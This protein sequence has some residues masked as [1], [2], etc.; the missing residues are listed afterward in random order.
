MAMLSHVDLRKG[1]KVEI[2]GQPYVIIDA[3]FVKPGKGSAFTRVRIRNYLNGNTIERT[4]K[5]ADKVHPAD[6]EQKSCQYLYN[7][8][9]DFHFMDNETYDQIMIP[10]ENLGDSWKWMSE[11]METQV[12][13]W[14]GRAISCELPKTVVLEIAQCD[15]GER[16]NTAQGASKP[17]TMSTGAT[18]NVPLFIN[19]GDH[20]R[21]DTS[22]GKYTERV[23]V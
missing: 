8:G 23:K 17:A 1:V 12:L 10:K 13:F 21:V 9:D 11:N 22:S 15:P 4:F 6:V 7:E 3:D 18:V 16:G 2:D 14:G 20:I 19:E 5:A